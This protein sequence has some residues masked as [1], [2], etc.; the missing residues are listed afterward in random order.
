MRKRQEEWSYLTGF[1]ISVA[2]LERE[3]EE[4]EADNSKI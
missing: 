1:E 4:E 3:F 2:G